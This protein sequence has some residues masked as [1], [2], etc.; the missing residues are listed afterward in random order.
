MLVWKEN[1]CLSTPFPHGDGGSIYNISLLGI[2]GNIQIC[3]EISCLPSPTAQRDE[4]G[5]GINLEIHNVAKNPLTC[6]EVH[7]ELMSTS[8]PCGSG[9]QFTKTFFFLGIE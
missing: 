4:G 9:G 5:I 8:I 7:G 3:T 2:E 1:S 6:P